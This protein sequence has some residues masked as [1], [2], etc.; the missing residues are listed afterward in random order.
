MINRDKVHK[1]VISSNR[2]SG[3]DKFPQAMNNSSDQIK[4]KNNEKDNNKD[5]YNS[6]AGEGEVD[7]RA[8]TV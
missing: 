2:S 8:Q 6:D 5:M 4:G 3:L 7:V 1:E